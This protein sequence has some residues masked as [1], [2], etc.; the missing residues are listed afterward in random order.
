MNIVRVMW[1]GRGFCDFRQVREWAGLRRLYLRDDK[2]IYMIL[3]FNMILMI[4]VNCRQV[5]EWAGLRRL[6]LQDNNLSPAIIYIY[7]YCF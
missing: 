5:R 3:T 6:D 4:Y 2:L 7:I 1:I